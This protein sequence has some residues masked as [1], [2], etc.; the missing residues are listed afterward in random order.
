MPT[1]PSAAVLARQPQLD[2]PP[3]AY[4]VELADLHA[5]LYRITLTVQ[6]P[7]AVQRVSLP[8]WIPGS[9]MVREFSKHLQQLEAHQ[10]RRT[11][12]CTQLDKHSWEL[13][14]EPGKPLVLRYLVYAHDT[15]VRTAF[16]DGRRGFFNGTSLFLR[17]H[18][19]EAQPH[20][21][22][23]T[24]SRQAVG[25]SVATGLQPA[26]V[27]EHGFG[28]YLAPDYDDLVDCPVEL[29]SFWH[30]EFKACG[31]AHRFV[32]AGAPPSFDGNRLLQDTQKICEQQIRFWHQQHGPAPHGKPPHRRYVFLLNAVDDGYGGLEHRNS[33]ALVCN[34]RDLP[35]RDEAGGEAARQGEG[36]T[37]LLGLI[38][39]EYFH[40]WN[41]KR[42]RPAEFA[43][44]DYDAEQYTRLLWFF[45]GFTSYYDD[46]LLR[47]CGLLEN[48][49]Y[50]RLLNKTINQVMQTPGR[51][52]QSAAE[53]SM[54]AWVKYYRTDEN[55]PNAT[56]SYYAKGALVALCFDLTL[57]LE[58]K[59][60]L[61]DV[62]RRLWDRCAAGPMSEADVAAVLADVGGR[63]FEQEL[64][65]WVHGRG[66]L[67][68]RE[69]LTRH[70]VAIH[71]EPSQLAQRLGL[72][73]SD[74]QGSV[75][76]KVVLR[77][78]AAEQAGMAAGDEWIGVETENE[79]WRLSR[80]DDLL[81][82]T[83]RTRSITALVAR[84]KLLMRLRLELP[85]LQDEK[86]WRID[87][88]NQQA[89]DGWLSGST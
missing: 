83:G 26:A 19:Q 51:L 11:V 24:P 76:L 36:Y 59:G 38:S 69:L 30:G 7:A 68:L 75:Q 66:D 65:A 37:T 33:T 25:W 17:V 72:R 54:D 77:G 52:I 10:G 1:S 88:E 57:R 41:V 64:A 53:A 47:R 18:G 3:I 34:R 78:G 13:Q 29:G 12:A 74:G 55:T 27:D 46:L 42:L 73:A 43:R 4:H 6:A 84:D 35:R 15:S 8:V 40:T 14:A 31:I 48:T 70:G 23:L 56:V 20:G 85:A 71:D 86:T 61:D 67:P 81:L 44:Y 28:H 2:T 9:Y 80:L 58:G 89:V 60:T 22:E 87:I 32:V 50:L 5:H 45:E 39:H 63:S 16:L 21:L 62:M 82:Y 79:G 49:G